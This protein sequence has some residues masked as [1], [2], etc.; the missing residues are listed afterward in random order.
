MGKVGILISENRV[1]ETM[2]FQIEM[3]RPNYFFVIRTGH[4]Y[5]K[6]HGFLNAFFGLRQS[7]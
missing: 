4:L 7:E 5:L 3:T 1:L 2:C 6:T